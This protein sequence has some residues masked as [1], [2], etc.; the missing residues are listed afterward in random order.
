M[1]DQKLV[2]RVRCGGDRLLTLPPTYGSTGIPRGTLDNPVTIDFGSPVNDPDFEEHRKRGNSRYDIRGKRKSWAS[3]SLQDRR[4]TKGVPFAWHTYDGVSKIDHRSAF[5]VEYKIDSRGFP[6]NPFMKTGVAGC[7]ELGNWAVNWAVDPVVVLG[8]DGKVAKIVLIERAD[9]VLRKLHSPLGHLTREFAIPGGIV[10][11]GEVASATLLREFGEEATGGTKRLT[12]DIKTA[13]ARSKLV[14]KGPNF[15][16]E[17]N[18][19]N[20]WMETEVHFIDLRQV[21]V[22]HTLKAG[23]DASKVVIADVEYVSATDAAPATVRVTVGDEEVSM[24]SDHAFFLS[25]VIQ[26]HLL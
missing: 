13:F 18:T 20:A 25:A 26:N 5:P 16:D 10:E 14:Y 6:V 9:W 15:S 1:S 7:G 11:S 17:R 8:W 12:G 2:T 23:S 4:A 24:Y 21:D 19:D 22:S 3:E